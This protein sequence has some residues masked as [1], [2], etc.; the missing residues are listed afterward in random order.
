[1]VV[2]AAAAVAATAAFRAVR[3]VPAQKQ[4]HA[5][6]SRISLQVKYLYGD[7]AGAQR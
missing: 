3:F 5:V 1:M 2:G 6:K 4:G 7:S